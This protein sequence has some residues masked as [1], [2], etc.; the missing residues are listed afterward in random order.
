MNTTQLNQIVGQ[1]TVSRARFL[2][3]TL[4]TP[5]LTKKNRT[6]KA[7]TDFTVQIRSRFRADLGVDYENEVNNV[8]EFE[9][10]P[11]DFRAQAP[12]GK[13]YV[14]GSNWLMQADSDPEKYYVALSSVSDKTT[15]Y[16]IDGRVATPAEV[17][18][19]QINYLP[20]QSGKPVLVPWRTYSVESIQSMVRI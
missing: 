7:P 17:A 1:P 19:L 16:L 9:G 14:T 20:A 10:K 11:R 18:D 13:H 3:E 15:E 8:L 6:T 5:K 4:T 12:S 2:F